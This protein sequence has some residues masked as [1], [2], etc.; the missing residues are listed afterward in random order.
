MALAVGARL[1][2][3]EIV[4]ALG[5]GGMGEVYRARDTKLNRDVAIK[6]LPAAVAADRDRL[7][8]F[9]REAQ[10]LAA[11]NHPHIAHIHGF[12][13]STDTPALVMELVEG[14][15]LADRIAKGPLPI[16]ET[17]AIAK[18]I[19]AALEAA[20]DR[21]IIHRDLKPANVKLRPDGTVKLL[22]FGLAKALEPVSP[23][24]ANVT[25]SPTN[26][27]AMTEMGVILGTAAYM[28]P[29][30][31][32]GEAVD[33]RADIWAFGVVLFEMLTGAPLFGRKTVA[34]TITAVLHVEPEWSRV[35]AN[36]RLLL[37]TCLEK[38]P[39]RR[40]HDIV[41]G[42]LLLDHEQS[43]AAS[44][45]R[46]YRGWVPW[47]VAAGFAIAAAVAAWA[48]WRTAPPAAQFVRFQIAP[49]GDL[50]ASAASAISPNGRYLAFLSS[51][52]DRV[53][54]VWVRDLRSGE[55]RQLQGTEIGQAAPPPFWS[56]DSRFIAYDAGGA[57][58]MVDVSGGLAQTVCELAH[59]AI[60]GSWNREGVI[61]F[62]DRSRGI[63]KVSDAGGVASPVTA[64]DSSRID[65]TPVF[66]PDGRHFFYLRAY[67]T[68]PERTGIFIGSLDLQPQEQ[69]SRRLVATTTSPVYA[70][71]SDG[72]PGRLLFLRDGNLMAQTFDERRLEL[73]GAPI[74][75]ADHVHS[76]LDTTTASASENNILVY[77]S[78]A[79]SQL[80]WYDR[81][82]R[83][84]GHLSEPGL[85]GGVNLSPDGRR[86]AVVRV[87]SQVTSS[88]TLWL[89]E[90]ARGTSTR[91]TSTAAAL[92]AVWSPDGRHIALTSNATSL[93]QIP[94][95]GTGEE[96]VLLQAAEN[97]ISPTSWS[98]DGR[99]LLY[100]VVDPKTNSDV[101]VLSLDGSPKSVAFLR[102]DA[103]ESQ[104]QFSPDPQGAPRWVAYTSN[105]SGRDEVQLRTFPDAQN[106]LVVSSGGGHSPKWR[107]D[108]KELF[109]L[110]SNGTVMV[111]A[112][113]GNP[114]G[115]GAPTPL[116]QAPRGFAAPDATG[117]H[118]SAAWDVTPDGQ[119]FLL[120]APIAGG[121]TSPFT[122]VLNWQTGLTK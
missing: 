72:G 49:T 110:T 17:L 18:Q 69:G 78:T 52:S 16:D 106:R 104:A 70:R 8:R 84:V 94:T 31:A 109:Y 103:A 14:P 22:D 64:P 81:H 12:E 111:V 121:A 6:V 117:R 50:P 19:A 66:L 23:L 100:V 30:Q 74:L 60:G 87:N 40:L 15:T 24:N 55:D 48:F 112:V 43:G 61:L 95:S 20:H 105:E 107:R 115:L 26:A 32:R 92:A 118:S 35:P 41:D 68:D 91:L 1:G 85:Y 47:S 9:E 39:K 34:D 96:D 77:K 101:W 79:V 13:D 4:S 58:K 93:L 37:R 88:A 53:M 44:G 73:S 42:Q 3:Y 63:M 62:G 10:V 76:Y 25:A 116:F 83:V 27:P 29:E 97:R 122:V 80:T 46:T 90:F 119:R 56:P 51:G 28:S 71:A 113:S 2:P 36:T 21:A 102:S 75:V 114:L 82:G 120:A 59:P 45:Q 5:A 57:L 33:K 11:L 98:R 67:R 38:D 89:F 86:A 99:F 54:R 65:L 7:A 108:G